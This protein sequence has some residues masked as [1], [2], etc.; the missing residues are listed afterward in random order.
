MNKAIRLAWIGALVLFMASATAQAQ[1]PR[2]VQ[3]DDSVATGKTAT[4]TTTATPPMAPESIKVKYEGGVFGYNK[5]MDGTINFDD[6]NSRLL[7]RNKY[8][9]EIFSIP[10]SSVAS[11]F[12]DVKS[13]RP[14]AADV[15][16]R[17]SIFALPALLIK[18]KFRYLTLQ[19]NDQDTQM[20]GVTSFKM[21]NEDILASALYT[22]A[23]KANLKQRGDVYV[24]Q[25]KDTASTTADDKP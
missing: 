21:E 16:A 3:T 11:A 8:Q 24:K 12:A 20:N 2:S 10:Y 25:R 7:F 4:T 1:R 15:A 23:Q 19:Y 22:L 9:Q 17:A 18:K 5:K 13:K 14:I 6:A